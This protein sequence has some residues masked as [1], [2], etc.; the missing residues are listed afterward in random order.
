MILRR[1]LHAPGLYRRFDVV[2]LDCPPLI[3]LCC[4]NA[5]AASD[6]VLTPVV[7]SVKRATIPARRQPHCTSLAFGNPSFNARDVRSSSVGTLQPTLAWSRPHARSC[8]RLRDAAACFPLVPGERLGR[9]SAAR[10]VA[11]WSSRMPLQQF[12]P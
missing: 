4:A 3:N 5:L 1:A 11:L 10:I 12:Q 6:Y 7:P 9:F 8:A 2:L